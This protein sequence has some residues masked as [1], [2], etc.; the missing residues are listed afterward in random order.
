MSAPLGIVGAMDA[1]PKF[2]RVA[3]RFLEALVREFGP[4]APTLLRSWAS[5]L[6]RAAHEV[7]DELGLSHRE[8]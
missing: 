1:H 3:R 8:H 6:E 2:A 4:D 5:Y 7:E